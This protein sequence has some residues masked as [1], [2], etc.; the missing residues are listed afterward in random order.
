MRVASPLTLQPEERREL[1]RWSHGKSPH[2]VLWTAKADD[3]L[4][5]VAR[6]R[7]LQTTG[8]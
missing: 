2:Q 3:I 7:Q 4:R 8:E 1:E 5:K 6:I